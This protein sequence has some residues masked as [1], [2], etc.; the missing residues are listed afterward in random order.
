MLESPLQRRTF[1]LTA[2]V[3]LAANA[4][5]VVAKRTAFRSDRISV[6]VLG[7]GPDVVLIPGLTS[8]SE[9]WEGTVRAVPGH[10]YH[11]VQLNGFAGHP[12]QGNA[13]G[14]VIASAAEEIARYIRE[15]GL[16]RPALIGHS[17]G[18]TIALS[19]AAR[20]DLVSKVMVVDMLP[21]LGVV[22]VPPGS[23]AETLQATADTIRKRSLEA[24]AEERR[25]TIESGI[26]T[27]VRSEALRA[28]PIRHAIA[29]DRQVSARALHELILTDLRPE[30][31]NI[32]GPVTVLYVKTPNLPLTE[33]QIDA[34]YKTSYAGLDAVVLKRIPDSYHFIMYD[35]PEVFADEV[36]GFLETGK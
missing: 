34:L 4:V 22:F 27:M 29:S 30:L 36:R 7:S 31:P 20:H 25:A 35:K 5:P 28:T 3:I 33:A 6:R 17:M 19:I 1:L 21:A 13:S 26:A 24:T 32:R 12:A 23:S 14:A 18:G 8:S 9:I 10:R 15:R 2:G 11:L 16:K